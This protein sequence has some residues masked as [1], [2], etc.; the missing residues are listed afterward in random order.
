MRIILSVLF[1]A[2]TEN[3]LWSD[4]DMGMTQKDSEIMRLAQAYLLFEVFIIVDIGDDQVQVIFDVETF[5]DAAH[6]WR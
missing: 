5:F 3:C 2:Y 6:R 4:I 1:S